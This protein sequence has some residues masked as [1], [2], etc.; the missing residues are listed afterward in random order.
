MRSKSAILRKL[1]TRTPARFKRTNRVASKKHTSGT[2][3]KHFLSD[4]ISRVLRGKHTEKSYQNSKKKFLSTCWDKQLEFIPSSLKVGRLLTLP[5]HIYLSSQKRDSCTGFYLINIRNII[6][7]VEFLRKQFSPYVYG[8]YSF[9]HF[10]SGFSSAEFVLFLMASDQFQHIRKNYINISW[11]QEVVD[12]MFFV[13]RQLQCTTKYIYSQSTTVSASPRPNWG[14]VPIRTTGEKAQHSVYSVV[15]ILL[16]SSR[17]RLN[18]KMYRFN[19][20]SSFESY[21]EQD[22]KIC[23]FLVFL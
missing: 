11:H 10:T 2:D 21:I 12:G 14:G 17:I 3:K 16:S 13:K 1:V 15:T 7:R 20:R 4:L 19:S 18:P 22:E 6:I 9:C 8:V 5:G 23:V